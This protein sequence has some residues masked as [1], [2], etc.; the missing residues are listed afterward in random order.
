SPPN[1]AVGI[2]N[3]CSRSIRLEQELA[4]VECHRAAK[5]GHG[6]DKLPLKRNGRARWQSGNALVPLLVK[7]R[8]ECD[9]EADAESLP[10]GRL[11]ELHIHLTRCRNVLNDAAQAHPT[12][13]VVRCNRLRLRRR[14]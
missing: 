11:I 14:L 3:E 9:S 5:I 7:V 12:S 10:P 13:E 4:V 2:R 8:V 6:P 1:K